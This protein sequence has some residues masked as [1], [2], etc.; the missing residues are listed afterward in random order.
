M[1]A[2]VTF[3]DRPF[4]F[5]KIYLTAPGLSCCIQDLQFS[6]LHAGF[7][8]RMWDLIPWPE[9]K[10]RPPALGAQRLTR[11]TTKE[12]PG[13][14]SFSVGDHSG[15]YSVWS[16]IPG[17]CPLDTRRPPNPDKQMPPDIAWHPLE[18]GS[19]LIENLWS[20][21]ITTKPSMHWVSAVCWHSLKLISV[22]SRTTYKGENDGSPYLTDEET[23]LSSG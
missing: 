16:S 10:P 6:L 9:I 11:W 14:R 8:C 7:S 21:E 4:F 2:L 20:T 18:I 23:E 19:P 15:Y 13:A 3:G 1:S 22:Q 17:P 12:V 5:L